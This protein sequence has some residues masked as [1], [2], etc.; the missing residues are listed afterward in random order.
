M[1]PLSIDD[2]VVPLEKCFDS[3]QKWRNC[4]QVEY[5]RLTLKDASTY[6][7]HMSWICRLVLSKCYLCVFL[8]SYPE[9][10]ELSHPQLVFL[11]KDCTLPHIFLWY[12][13]NE[14]PLYPNLHALIDSSGF[15]FNGNFFGTRNDFCVNC[16]S[17][18][19]SDPSQYFAFF[20][21]T[22]FERE[23]VRKWTHFSSL[24]SSWNR[25]WDAGDVGE[26]Q[27]LT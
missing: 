2:I 25:F 19:V 9:R 5:R 4:R 27:K 7:K 24:L 12:S 8:L 21:W 18:R 17:N 11:S 20:L 3:K 22:N 13:K 15:N 6:L 10:C 23:N 14:Y 26:K 1:T 16:E